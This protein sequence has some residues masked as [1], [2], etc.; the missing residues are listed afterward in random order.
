MPVEVRGDVVGGDGE[1]ERAAV[2]I[3]GSHDLQEGPVDHVHLCL[4]FAVGEVHGLTADE[5]GLLGEVCGAGPV[6]GEVGEGGLSAP[7]GG[8][9][10]VIDEL[11]QALLDLLEAQAIQADEG[12]HVGIE[13]GE[14]LGTGPLVLQ[15]A[16]EVDGLAASA[17]EVAR[18]MRGDR[19]R[20]PAEAF[21]EE[22]AQG[23]AG[24]VAGEAVEV[25]DVNVAGAV[26]GT[27]RGGED[28]VQPVVRGNLSGGVEDESA[29]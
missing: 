22:L 8:H 29:D 4:E 6:E 16:E 9:V 14:R 23:P 25:V 24:A 27:S 20:N 10:E 1:G 11:L 19:A 28:L 15:G 3:P 7:T 17:G 2:G 13:A 12:G 5:W 21:L 26:G 18:W